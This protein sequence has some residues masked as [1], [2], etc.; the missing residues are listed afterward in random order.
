MPETP[1]TAATATEEVVETPKTALEVVRERREQIESAKSPESKPAA[2]PAEAPTTEEKASESD[3]PTTATPE[4]KSEEPKYYSDAELESMDLRAAAMSRVRP[5]LRKTIASLQKAEAKKHKALNKK[6]DELN[7]EIQTIKT[8]QKHAVE[9]D[10]TEEDLGDLVADLEDPKT[11]SKAV[12]AL[13]KSE[14]GKEALR[15]MFGELGLTPEAIE[16]AQGSAE[17]KTLGEAFALAEKTFPQLKDEA[18]WTRVM[19]SIEEDDDDAEAINSAKSAREVSRII[20][21]HAGLIASNVAREE[22]QEK[23][24][25]KRAAEERERKERLKQETRNAQTQSKAAGAPRKSTVPIGDGKSLT[26]LEIVRQVKQE[27]QYEVLK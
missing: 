13:L 14:A 4:Q 21:A 17:M 20:K 16:T 10:P 24:E 2:Q 11:R 26:A 7:A 5:E 8:K 6:L 12:K 18:F 23:T 19:E 27:R 22:A 25:T 15:E 9:A 1:E 3:T